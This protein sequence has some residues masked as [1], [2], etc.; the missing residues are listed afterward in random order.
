MT[1]VPCGHTSVA[2]KTENDIEFALCN[3]EMD[4]CQSKSCG[5]GVLRISIT[6]AIVIVFS[7]RGSLPSYNIELYFLMTLKIKHEFGALWTYVL[8]TPNRGGCS[9]SSCNF[10]T[11]SYYTTSCGKIFQGY[12][13]S[14]ELKL[15]YLNNK[16]W[17][18]ILNCIL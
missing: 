1:L 10:K 17:I 11:D 3:F 16:A 9:S 12:Q 4:L 7:K 8:G 18:V 2:D 15:S 14:P 5:Q 6:S 13:L